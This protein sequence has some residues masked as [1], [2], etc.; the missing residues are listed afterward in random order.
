MNEIYEK[1]R[2]ETPRLEII[3]IECEEVMAQS[4]KVSLDADSSVSGPARA[5]EYRTDWGNR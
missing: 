1:N 5:T 2:Y 4:G 3:E